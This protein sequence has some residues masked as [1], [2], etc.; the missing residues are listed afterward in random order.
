MSSFL[1]FC[2]AQIPA[3]TIDSL[4]QTPRHNFFSLVR[5]STQSTFDPFC[6]NP[7]VAPFNSDFSSRDQIRAF[8]DDRLSVTPEA[9]DLESCQYAILDERSATD[10]TIILA[11]SY[12][13]LLMRDPETMTEDEL[14]Q[15]EAECDE[16]EDESDDSWREWRVEFKDAE[17]LS[18]ILCFEEDFTVKLYNDDFVTTH[19]NSEGV[20]QLRA[21]YRAFS[22][23]EYPIRD[24]TETDL[25][26]YKY[27]AGSTVIW[28]HSLFHSFLADLSFNFAVMRFTVPLAI[29]L[30]VP[31]VTNALHVPEGTPDGI[32]DLTESIAGT[33]VLSKVGDL[34]D[35]GLDEAFTSH[36]IPEDL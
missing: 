18:T 30:G 26:I 1:L 25:R 2:V 34:L 10:Q 15:W 36:M 4:L 9:S 29:C 8:L 5:E 13:T 20:F 31:I 3:S 35:L 6:T 21:A 33:A 23:T 12:S 17:P 19:T 7:P 32:Y 14:E 11:H 27:W 24:R 16:H 28:R 22:G